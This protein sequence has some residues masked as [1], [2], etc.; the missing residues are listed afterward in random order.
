MNTLVT[1]ANGQLGHALAR[2]VPDGIALTGADLPILDITDADAVLEYCRSLNPDLVINAAAYTAVDQA[3]SDAETAGRVNADGAR[4]VAIAAG[5]AGARLIQISTD[6]VFDGSATE[7]YAPGAAT[8]P[9]GVYGRTKRDGELAVLEVLPDSA[10][11]VRTSWLYGARGNNFVNT[12]L[13]LMSE[14]DEISVVADQVG[15][16]TWSDSLAAAIWAFAGRPGLSGVYHWTDGG[17]TSWHGFATAIQE[18]ALELGL[19]DRSIPIHP[20]AT[21][22]YP[23]AATRPGYSVLDT[24]KTRSALGLQA[25]HWRVNLRHMLEGL[26]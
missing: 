21:E 15:S 17:Q 5:D 7:P 3:E 24:R 1:G 16:P 8:S 20:V 14:R 13:R 4:N 25:G 18:E 23:T 6:F 22:D 10:I 2:S 19:L 26:T 11:I 12:M 9:L